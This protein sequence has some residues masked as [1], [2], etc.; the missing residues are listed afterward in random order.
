MEVASIFINR[1]LSEAVKK[2]AN[3]LHLSIGSFPMVRVDGILSAMKNEGIISREAL[4]G[5]INT[6]VEDEDW[7]MVEEDKGVVIVR[8][9]PGGLRFRINIFFQKN[10][11]TVAFY[12]VSNKLATLEELDMPKAFLNFLTS[13][14]G[15]LIIAGPF[16][17]GKSSTIS[18]FINHINRTQFK[19]IVTLED[20]IER[21][22]ISQKS[23]INQRQI[24]QDVNSFSDGLNFC[25][26]QSLDL[27]YVGDARSN[28]SEVMPLVL[29]LA[30]GNSLVI[31]EVNANSSVNVLEKILSATYRNM[32]NEAAQYCLADVL[33]G[34]LVQNLLPKKGGGMALAT[35]LLIANPAIK[36]LIR[37][38]KL[39]Q[40]ENVIESA[41]LEG[42]VSMKKS[43][44]KLTQTGVIE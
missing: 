43:I 17:S 3:S 8:D 44:Y 12:L 23:I 21:I 10:L 41:G 2:N 33:N 11:P 4:T 9:F 34:I 18:A 36:A 1:L 6:I 35:E 42:M 28:L 24:G 5:V 31:L 38:G 16:A 37:E 32:S 13:K 40:V 14:S 25:L 7:K 15:L 22:Y 20:P 39:N 29:N 19:Y 26:D 30:A 27:V